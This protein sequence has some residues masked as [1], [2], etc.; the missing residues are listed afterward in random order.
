MLW[1][2]QLSEEIE[3]LNSTEPVVNNI[4]VSFT[5]IHGLLRHGLLGMKRGGEGQ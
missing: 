2:S 3:V 4:H 5:V 1:F